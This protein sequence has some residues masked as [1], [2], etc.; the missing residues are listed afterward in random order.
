M[1][2]RKLF[3]LEEQQHGGL[4]EHTKFIFDHL[5]KEN[6]HTNWDLVSL[7]FPVEEVMLHASVEH[8]TRMLDAWKL[9]ARFMAEY[10]QGQWDAGVNECAQREMLVPRSGTTEVNSQ[11]W[12]AVS[13]SWNN[14]VRQMRALC[15]HPGINVKPLPLTKCLKLTAGDQMQWAEHDGKGVDPDTQVFAQLAADGLLS[16]TALLGEVSSVEVYERV[17]AICDKVQPTIDPSGSFAGKNLRQRWLGN[18]KRWSTAT[19]Q[20]TDSICGVPV[21]ADKATADILKV[22]GFAGAK[23]P[24]VTKDSA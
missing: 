3:T 23:P 15:A 4:N 2:V 5:V 16:W 7:I 18:P 21:K 22:L 9:L 20:D 17:G 11:G 8:C 24:H 14:F 6:P 10:L 19:K 13:G 12:N 1:S